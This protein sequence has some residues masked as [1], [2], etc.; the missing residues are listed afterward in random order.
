MTRISLTI[1]NTS[2]LVIDTLH[3]QASKED[4]A[5]VILY[6]DYQEQREQTTANMIG[7]ILKQLVVKGRIPGSVRGALTKAK[8]ECG[9]RGLRL[10]DLVA[11][12]R[13]S[14]AS[15]S[16]VFVCIDALDEFVPEKLPEFLV[17]LR[18]IV[19]GLPNVHVFLTGRPYVGTQIPG[20]FAEVV[21]ILI[22]PKQDEIRNYLR[23]KFETAPEPHE[24]NNDLQRD[25]I[26][27][28]Q[29]SIS[30][31]LVQIS[32]HMNEHRFTNNYAQIPPCFAKYRYYSER[33][34]PLQQNKKVEADVKR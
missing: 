34:D 4:I 12:L 30:K 13:E 24:M 1:S 16:Q 20:R 9:S 21:T 26:D 6:C 3:E 11:I 22:S 10:L 27:F 29:G 32:P 7:S 8:N 15:L 23:R 25:I 14:I 31:S 33:G 19:Q 18:D 17:S 2:S 5:V 28:I